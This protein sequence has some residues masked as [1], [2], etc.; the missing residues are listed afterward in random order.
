VGREFEPLPGHRKKHSSKAAD[1]PVSKKSKLKRLGTS[2]LGPYA[3][4]KQMPDKLYK[5]LA[6]GPPINYHLKF[7]P[8]GTLVKVATVTNETPNLIP[9]ISKLCEKDANVSCA[10][11]CDEG[12]RHIGKQLQ[13]EGGFCGYRN[14][15]MMISYIQATYGEGRHPFPGMIPSIIKLQDFIEN[16]WD[17]G[18]NPHGR[19]ETGGIK[20]TRKYIGTSEAKTLFTSLGISCGAKHLGKQGNQPAHEAL[21]DFV[22]R[23]YDEGRTQGNNARIVRTHRPPMYIQHA[24]HSMTII[25]LELYKD[26]SRGLLVFDP[27]FSPSPGIRD[28]VGAKRIGSKANIWALLK[29]HRRGTQY[30]GKYKEF[31]LLFVLPETKQT[32]VIEDSHVHRHLRGRYS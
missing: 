26:G 11:L 25:G 24:G 4:E 18:I 10:W 22:Q 1:D 32:G 21:Y 3:M 27:S 14:I 29:L 6:N 5:A 23:Y 2:E 13:K 20:G 15:Q 28:L 12:V 31:E 7:G 30:L 19:V 8:N 17:M 9:V 16:G